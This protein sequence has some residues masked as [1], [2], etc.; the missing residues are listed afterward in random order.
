MTRVSAPASRRVLSPQQLAE[1]HHAHQPVEDGGD[2]RQRLGGEFDD[3]HQPSA[4][5]VFCQID[6]RAHPQGQND[7]QGEHDDI[8][9]VEDVGQDA[10]GVVEIALLRR[11]QLP[12]DAGQAAGQNIEDQRRRK[13]RREARAKADEAAQRQVETAA[14]G[15][16]LLVNPFFSHAICPPFCRP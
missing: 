11:D 13:P 3:P 1:E 2:A 6:R 14:P 16:Q 10:D 4:G 9:R 5:C 8:Q 12:G 15:R 7:G